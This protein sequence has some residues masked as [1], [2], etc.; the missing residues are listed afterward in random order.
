MSLRD[1]QKSHFKPVQNSMSTGEACFLSL[2][3]NMIII[4]L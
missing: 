1:S 2:F 4:W 3:W